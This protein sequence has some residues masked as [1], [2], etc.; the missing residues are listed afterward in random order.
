M[1][2][3]A[4]CIKD[5]VAPRDLLGCAPFTEPGESAALKV[6]GIPAAG[7]HDSVC[8]GDFGGPLVAGGKAIGVVST[9]NKYCDD[10]PGLRLH[11]G[12]RHRRRARPPGRV[13]RG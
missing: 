7:T 3:A 10:L 9:G 4:H 13:T 6:C 1:L 2:T 12:Q 8:R 5:A 11:P